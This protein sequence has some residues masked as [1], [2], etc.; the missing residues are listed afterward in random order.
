[1]KKIILIIAVLLCFV[2]TY[3]QDTKPTKQETMDWIA[4]K[5]KVC[6]NSNGS[7][8]ITQWSDISNKYT[9]ISYSNNVVKFQAKQERITNNEEEKKVTIKVYAINLNLLTNIDVY[10]NG[11]LTIKG[12]KDFILVTNTQ[13][14]EIKSYNDLDLVHNH[15]DWGINFIIDFNKETNLKE[16]MI[17]AFQVL[18]EYNKS[19]KP[20]E[21]F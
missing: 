6:I 18:G 16:R 5:F 10:S 15:D 17:K 11:N 2:N 4:E 8:L 9:F 14:N 13:P 12:E 19:Q 20:K 21:K 7:T 3:A 1:M